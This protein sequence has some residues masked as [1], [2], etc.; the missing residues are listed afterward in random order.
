MPKHNLRLTVLSK[1]MLS[2]E[3]DLVSSEQ[4]LESDFQDVRTCYTYGLRTIRRACFI[5]Y[6]PRL[7]S[8]TCTSIHARGRVQMKENSKIEYLA[9]Y[10]HCIHTFL[11]KVVINCNNINKN[12]NKTQR[13]IFRNK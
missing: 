9:T 11:R 4:S 10:P 5:K 13:T 12:N 1:N 8:V 7:T 6:H 3:E 2:P